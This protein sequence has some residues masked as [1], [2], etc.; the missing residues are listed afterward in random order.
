MTVGTPANS[1][2]GWVT[3]GFSGHSIRGGRCHGHIRCLAPHT[4]AIENPR[5]GT[6]CRTSL[7][8]VQ[9]PKENGTDVSLRGER[10]R[11]RE[12]RLCS[13]TRQFLWREDV[14]PSFCSAWLRLAEQ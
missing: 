3:R 8:S 5:V 13:G 6:Q 12:G 2:L 9:S 7:Q 1:A 10:P 4:M 14:W 11:P